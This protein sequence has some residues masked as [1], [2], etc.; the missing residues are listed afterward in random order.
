MQISRERTAISRTQLSR[1]VRLALEDGVITEG[2]SVFDFGCGRGEDLRQLKRLGFACNGWDPAF[3]SDVPLHSAPVVNIGYVVNVIEDARERVETLKS[4][5]ELAEKVL[6]VSARLTLEAQRVKASEFQDGVVTSAGTFQKFY[7]QQELRTWIDQTLGV[8]SVPTAPGV[9]YV[10]RESE[11][12]EQFINRKYVGGGTSMPVRKVKGG[13]TFSSSG[14]PLY[15]TLAAA[16]R[17]YKAYLA[18]KNA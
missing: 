10:F 3:R 11:D 7:G 6:V 18:K 14:R 4:A 13:W 8:R 15:K 12:R 1:P 5:W 2:D 9:F 16:K 17:A